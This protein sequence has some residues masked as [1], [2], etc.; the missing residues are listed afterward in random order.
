[1]CIKMAQHGMDWNRQIVMKWKNSYTMVTHSSINNEY[2]FEKGQKKNHPHT[3]WTIRQSYSW[4]ASAKL[5]LSGCSFFPLSSY[6]FLKC[7]VFKL[8]SL[9]I[10]S[11]HRTMNECHMQFDWRFIRFHVV[12]GIWNFLQSTKEE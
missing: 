7:S 12:C 10:F 4:Y 1:M 5:V 9:S 6:K 8:N 2:I 3:K 11:L